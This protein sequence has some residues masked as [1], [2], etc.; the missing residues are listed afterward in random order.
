[1]A[2]S[3]MGDGSKDLGS[4]L[5]AARLRKGLSLR[6]VET[7]TSI[8]N[9]YLSQLE[10]GKTAQPS[11]HILRKL[12]DLYGVAYASIMTAA[13][14][15]G[16]SEASEVRDLFLS[17][18]NT[19]KEVVRAIASDLADSSGDGGLSVWVDEAEI[20]PGASIP[21]LVNTGLESSRFI[22]LVMT[23]RY[24]ESESGWTDAEWHAALAEDPDNRRGRIIPLLV[25]D[26]PYIPFLL[27]HLRAIDVRGTRYEAGLR[28]LL[29]VLR[30]E[31]LPRPVT[32]RGQLI[33]SGSRIDRATLVAERA[34]PDADPDVVNE[35]LYCNLLPVET[36]PRN[37]YLATVSPKLIARNRERVGLPPKSRL[38]E[39]IRS[40]QDR[41]G[42][43][44]EQRFMPAFRTY[45]DKIITFHDLEEA[46]GPL[47]SIIDENEIEI[48]DLPTFLRDEELRK[49]VISLI[50]M[51]LSRHL[52]RAGLEA[53]DGRQGRFFFPAKE[54]R[55]HVITWTPR[56]R[57]ATRT[58]A[59]PVLQNG[60]VMYWRHLGAYVETIFLASRMY[61]KVEP[62]WVISKDGLHP[63]GGPEVTRRVA[64]WTRPERN[65]QVLFHIRFWT[66]VL[67]GNRGGPITIRAGDQR[68]EVATV[69]AMI[70]QPYGIAGDQRDL[71]QLLDDEAPVLAA[72]EEELSDLALGEFGDGAAEESERGN[73]LAESEEEAEDGDR[74]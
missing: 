3:V 66:S 64:R 18:R 4:V 72:E 6:Q 10:T 23:P 73:E 59:K 9:G 8:S 39:L 21:G 69:P 63:S 34:V 57:K 31:P 7:R 38:R 27:R 14:Y 68:I 16:Q 37:I 62:T 13:G 67:R 28:E 70:Q 19:D 15:A 1:M 2:D 74:E 36:L 40:W 47:S 12:S 65:L 56:R 51:A 33:T 32:H 54:E 52:I 17:H 11:P 71:L 26:C 49:I 48:L 43:P 45:E 30:G 46:D 50:N 42:L 44:V 41:N 60:K 55:T 61:V 25:E 22:G 20:R 24:F 58:V 29:A 53:D 5:R 35:R